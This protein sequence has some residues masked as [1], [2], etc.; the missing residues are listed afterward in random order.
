MFMTK[1]L[2]FLS[3][4]LATEGNAQT[5]T[6]KLDTASQFIS[7]IGYKAKTLGIGDRLYFRKVDT[8][9]L[10]RELITPIRCPTGPSS[11]TEKVKRFFKKLTR[12][13][14]K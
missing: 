14:L 4:L 8:A 12:G 3:V 13:W 5:R 7:T 11:N 10:Y 1:A 9:A 2:F 6:V